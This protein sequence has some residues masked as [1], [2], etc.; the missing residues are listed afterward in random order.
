MLQVCSDE[1]EHAFCNAWRTSA[2]PGLIRTAL[3][4]LSND[5]NSPGVSRKPC[6]LMHVGLLT[7]RQ[8]STY[9]SMV[10][11]MIYDSNADLIQMPAM[12]MFSI[13]ARRSVHA[14]PFPA[15]ALSSECSPL[16]SAQS[17]VL[18]L[19]TCIRWNCMRRAGP[20]RCV[21]LCIPQLLLSAP[22]CSPR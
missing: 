22:T 2:H 5:F 15:L 19:P 4:M 17:S 10:K 18:H 1:I 12:E 21:T 20:H 7:M 14:M 6:A 11:G 9:R 16:S 8:L 13:I 3:V